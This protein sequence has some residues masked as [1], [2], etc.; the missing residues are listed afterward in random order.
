[1]S[2]GLLDKQELTKRLLQL[3]VKFKQEWEGSQIAQDLFESGYRSYN[4]GIIEDIYMFLQRLEGVEFTKYS[5][6]R[7]CRAVEIKNHLVKYEKMVY[8][9]LCES[10]FRDSIE[11]GSAK[12]DRNDKLF[13]AVAVRINEGLTSNLIKQIEQRL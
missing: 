11:Y 9:Y 1:M 12:L 13:V 3:D 2:Y 4:S 5:D 8:D 7:W 6:E 10:I